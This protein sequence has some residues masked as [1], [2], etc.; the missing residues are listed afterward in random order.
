MQL[1]QGAWYNFEIRILSVGVLSAPLM[2]DNRVFE[3]PGLIKEVH[4]FKWRLVNIKT[5]VSINL[6]QRAPL[7][8][9]NISL[10]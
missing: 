9:L 8:E 7:V 2:A 6:A 3:R 4:L 10:I 5:L 1:S